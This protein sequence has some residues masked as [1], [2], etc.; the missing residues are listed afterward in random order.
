MTT[1]RYWGVPYG[2]LDSQSRLLAAL[3]QLYRNRMISEKTYTARHHQVRAIVA[4][5]KSLGA[6]VYKSGDKFLFL[7]P[8]G[9]SVEIIEKSVQIN[10][11]R[12]PSEVSVM[13]EL[14]PTGIGYYDPRDVHGCS[15]N[16]TPD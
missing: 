12:P 1:E 3:G 8:S 15:T 7:F 11:T 4:H 16:P 10:E 2:L 6:T 13:M 9:R 14:D 5:A